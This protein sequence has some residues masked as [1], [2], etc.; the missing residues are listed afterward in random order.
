MGKS[1]LMVTNL[2]SNL[3]VFFHTLEGENNKQVTL[4]KQCCRGNYILV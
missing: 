1:V 3:I 4:G 2:L